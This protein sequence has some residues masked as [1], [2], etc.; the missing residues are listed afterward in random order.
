[1]KSI[2]DAQADAADDRAASRAADAGAERTASAARDSRLHAVIA[3]A[4]VAVVA[5]LAFRGTIGATLDWMDEGHI[6]YP[7]WRVAHGATPYVDFRQLYGPSVFYWNGALLRLFGDDLGV[8]RAGVLALKVA[9]VVL[10]TMLTR[11]VASP[12]ATVAATGVAIALYGMPAWIVNTPYA[13]HYGVLLSFAALLV[14]LARRSTGAAFVAGLCFGVAATFKQTQGLFALA[15]FVVF[16]V[17]STGTPRGTASI[18]VRLCRVAIVLAAAAV[19]AAYVGR[20]VA[21]WPVDVVVAPFVLSALAVAARDVVRRPGARAAG[22]LRDAVVASVG[23][24]LPIAAYVA[25]FASI[26]AL[27]ELVWQTV[28]GLPQLVDWFVPLPTPGAETIA[29]W[30]VVV[31][32]VAVA[33]LG[34]GG[35]RRVL[36]LLVGVAA[37]VAFGVPIAFAPDPSSAASGIAWTM[38]PWLPAVVLGLTAW[39]LASGAVPSDVVVPLG[40]LYFYAAGAVLQLHPGADLPHVVMVLVA[41]L[42]LAAH[43]ATP[44][45]RPGPAWRAGIRAVVPAACV[46]LVAVPFVGVR[47][48]NPPASGGARFARATGVAVG[49]A[50]F[51]DAARLVATLGS[52]APKLFV[53]A[54]QQMLYFL[55]G[56]PSVLEREEYGFYLLG[57]GLL[58][59]ENVRLLLDQ[60][61]IWDVIAQEHPVIV[62]WADGPA[63]RRFLQ[64]FPRVA[65]LIQQTYRPATKIGGYRVRRWQGDPTE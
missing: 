63:G 15:S 42:P 48:A 62:D 56:V 41:F 16:L 38:L 11:R 44:A 20:R 8:L 12:A 46:A 53:L 55:A 1:M 24:A 5:V 26:G 43:L 51:A 60:D 35:W 32:T 6:V 17:W 33:G 28:R 2:A 64:T 7:S 45:R 54:D 23:F 65:D 57:D 34:P 27:H 22:G 37:L 31:A 19:A 49:G 39:T 36:G 40:A 14:Y 58:A 29:Q 30:A 3:A 9:I 13:A 52:T 18:A 25:Y 47:L 10:M 21:S 4:A 59:P 61:H 50:Q